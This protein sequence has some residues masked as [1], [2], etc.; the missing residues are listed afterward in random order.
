[1]NP[2]WLLVGLA[3]CLI[4]ITKSG[5]GSGV[6]LMIVPM[7][8]IALGHLPGTHGPGATLGLMLPLLVI[9]DLVAVAQHRRLYNG[10][11]VRRLLPGTVVGILAGGALLAYMHNQPPRMLTSLIKIEIGCESVGL[12][13]LQWYRNWREGANLVYRPSMIRSTAVGAFAGASS[14]LAHA[15]GPIVALHLLPQKLDRRVFVGTSAIYFFLLNTAKLPIYAA[16]GQFR[17][18]TLMLSMALLPLVFGGA[19]FGFWICRRLNDAA[20]SRIVYA[21]TFCL[22]WYLLQD[23]IRTLAG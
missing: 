23:G 13:A 6:G 20:F 11:I 22:G 21:V 17:S 7:T 2:W 5:F 9:G 14:T 12:V 8:V 15:A 3:V 4:G 1:M 16:S 18:D 19:A 10:T